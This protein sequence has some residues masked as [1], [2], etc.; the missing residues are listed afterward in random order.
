MIIFCKGGV[1]D[2]ASHETPPPTFP[3]QSEAFISVSFGISWW[4]FQA[5]QDIFC[6]WIM[7]FAHDNQ[8]PP[9]G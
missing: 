9:L 4:V 3:P 6:N 2:V 1:Q 7:Q 5:G 8:G